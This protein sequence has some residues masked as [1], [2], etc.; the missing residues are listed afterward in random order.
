MMPKIIVTKS[1]LFN[2]TLACHATW[3]SR[4]G[5]KF[6]DIEMCNLGVK[7]HSDE[8]YALYSK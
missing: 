7:S 3:G 1:C 2:V 4:V 8:I 5:A 6:Y